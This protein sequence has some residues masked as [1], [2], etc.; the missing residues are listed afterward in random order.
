[1]SFVA[2][3]LAAGCSTSPETV[4]PEGQV[5]EVMGAVPAWP[6]EAQA[7]CGQRL[8]ATRFNDDVGMRAFSETRVLLTSAQAYQDY[9]GHPAPAGVNPGR[10][11]IV[12]YASGKA[13]YT[14]SVDVVGV[15][16]DVLHV[17][18]TLTSPIPP[19]APPPPAP[20][21]MTGTMAGSTGTGGGSTGNAGAPA[22]G[23][24]TMTAP[25]A[26]LPPRQDGGAPDARRP[27]PGYVLVKFP[28]QKTR[29]VD[30]QHQDINPG[31]G[32][33]LPLPTNPCAAI[34]CKQ[35]QT[36][37]VL[38]SFPPQARCV[39][40]KPEP[41]RCRASAEC[42]NGMVCSVERGECLGCGAGPGVACPAVCY[43]VC[44][45]APS[46][47]SCTGGALMNEGCLSEVQWKERAAEECK[48]QMLELVD[49]GVGNACF[50]GGFSAAK[51][52][53]CTSKPVPPPTQ[54]P[55]S[56]PTTG[57]CKVDSDCRLTSTSCGQ[58]PC[59]CRAQSIYETQP[60]CAMP[61]IACLV[62]PCAKQIAT[63]VANRCVMQPAA[64][65]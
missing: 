10:E 23:G 44:E 21:T 53:C 52:T 13:G 27:G 32:N 47:G 60:S 55:P 58:D 24:P 9:F 56:P 38:E 29:S 22:P 1:M 61:A 54:T 48:K 20:G 37:V 43:G 16:G 34:L 45:P 36:C 14:P 42:A 59:T 57:V 7:S 30:F 5:H 18:T 8:V 65:R 19:C 12:F 33:D 4:E 63:C 11:W 31:C 46:G 25:A 64:T 62:D 26:P 28:A 6:G 35:G 2:L 51:Y 15:S 3:A 40:I 49:L 39:D 17:V 41:A 50:A